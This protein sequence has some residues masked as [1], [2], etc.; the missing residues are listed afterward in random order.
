MKKT[1]TKITC[2]NCGKTY[3]ID[4][5]PD[6]KYTDV[7]C[8][9]CDALIPLEDPDAGLVRVI[10]VRQEP[11]EITEEW[12]IRTWKT[13]RAAYYRMIAPWILLILLAVIAMIIYGASKS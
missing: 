10:V 12:V 3:E 5:D 4:L 8:P 7:Q 1:K 11:P 13:V 6:K 9:E 2:S